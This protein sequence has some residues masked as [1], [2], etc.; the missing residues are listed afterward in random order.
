KIL[1][2]GGG[3][4]NITNHYTEPAA[5]M[6]QNPQFCKTALARYTKRD[7]IDLMN[8]HAIRW[9]EKTR[10]QLVWDDSAPLVVDLVLKEGVAGQGTRGR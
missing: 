9:P 4:C 3:R 7:F 1:M 10:G 6:S 5:Y 2:S 8:R